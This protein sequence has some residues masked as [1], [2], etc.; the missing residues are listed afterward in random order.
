M[1]TLDAARRYR[2]IGWAILSVPAR[3]KAPIIKDW[4]KLRVA[5]A[6]L[7]KY[8]SDGPNIRAIL[9]S[10]SGGEIEPPEE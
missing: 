5:E 2:S 1:K 6:D 7:D 10:A 9:G 3:A 4:Q 8:F